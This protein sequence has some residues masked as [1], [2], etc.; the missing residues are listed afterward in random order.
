MA[1]IGLPGRGA[2][3][4]VLYGGGEDWITLSPP[5]LSERQCAAAARPLMLNP[6]ERLIDAVNRICFKAS[7]R[8]SAGRK[9]SSSCDSWNEHRLDL[10]DGKIGRSR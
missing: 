8:P 5:R 9:L 7:R 4:R 10:D 3:Q 1:A 2:S 6:V